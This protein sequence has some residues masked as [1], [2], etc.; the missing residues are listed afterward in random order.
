[1]SERAKIFLKGNRQIEQTEFIGSYQTKVTPGNSSLPEIALEE[2]VLAP[3]QTIIRMNGKFKT[4]FVIPLVGSFHFTASH[5]VLNK[6]EAEQIVV[7][8]LHGSYS[9][10]NQYQS[11]FIKFLTVDVP[12]PLEGLSTADFQ[13]KKNSLSEV[14]ISFNPMIGLFMGQYDGRKSDQIDLSSGEYSIIHVLQG[15]IEVQGRLLESGDSLAITNITSLEWESLSTE[16]IFLLIRS[17][18]IH[19]LTNSN[20]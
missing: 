16:T 14:F 7:N 11:E 8:S 3:S 9:I 19:P 18:I 13:L 12:I 6:I 5:K 10:Q 1:M 15:T 17:P 2:I 20:S 4:A